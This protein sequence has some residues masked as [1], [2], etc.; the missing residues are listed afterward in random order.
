MIKTSEFTSNVIL[1]VAFYESEANE[2]LDKIK[3]LT[4]GKALITFLQNEYIDVID[5]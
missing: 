5:E 2:L 4:L 3:N 1:N